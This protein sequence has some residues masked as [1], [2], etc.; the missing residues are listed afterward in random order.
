MEMGLCFLS[1][2]TSHDDAPERLMQDMHPVRHDSSCCS[3][4]SFSG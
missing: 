1:R 3:M 2:L 4:P